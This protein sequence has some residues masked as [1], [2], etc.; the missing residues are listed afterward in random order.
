MLSKELSSQ[1]DRL[2]KESEKERL[3]HERHY[4]LMQEILRM[5]RNI[6]P[7]HAHPQRTNKDLAKL[8]KYFGVKVSTGNNPWLNVCRIVIQSAANNPAYQGK[9]FAFIEGYAGYL[10]FFD[11]KL[12]ST[13]GRPDIKRFVATFKDTEFGSGLGAIKDRDTKDNRIHRLAAQSTVLA[14]VNGLPQELHA[15]ME[16]QAE[17]IRSIANADGSFNT[18]TVNNVVGQIN[19]LIKLL[20]KTKAR[21]TV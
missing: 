2:A 20:P 10:R 12:V 5:G 19:S 3:K 4:G 8:I 15:A 21:T 14:T 17:A 6:M 13:Q 9:D 16:R 7:T 1:L 11:R 18:M